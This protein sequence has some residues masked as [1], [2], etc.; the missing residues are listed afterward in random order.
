MALV[1]L[2]SKL[3]HS[4]EDKL[5]FPLIW[6]SWIV[7]GSSGCIGH[8]MKEMFREERGLM[9]WDLKGKVR[10]SVY[11]GLAQKTIQSKENMYSFC[12]LKKKNLFHT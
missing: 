5:M 10:L 6:E 11:C 7:S 8:E 3:R 9:G 1:I 2:T 4:Q 12:W